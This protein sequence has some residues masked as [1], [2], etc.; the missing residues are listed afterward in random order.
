MCIITRF[1]HAHLSAQMAMLASMTAHGMANDPRSCARAWA[2]LFVSGKRPARSERQNL[3][4]EQA[5]SAMHA[6]AHETWGLR[7]CF[8]VLVCSFTCADG[9]ANTHRMG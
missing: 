6:L 1:S 4:L 5:K 8:C 3:G 9:L 7:T 2:A